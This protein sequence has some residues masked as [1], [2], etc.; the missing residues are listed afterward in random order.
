MI[1]FQQIINGDSGLLAR[2]KI[3]AMLLALTEGEEGI[4]AVW[5]LIR[6]L[7]QADRTLSDEE[8]ADYDELLEFIGD[9]NSH[10][11]KEVSKVYA[12]VDA[13]KGGAGGLIDSP[14]Y[15]PSGFPADEAVTLIALGAGTFIH[16]PDVTGTPITI[17]YDNSITVFYRAANATYWGYNTK[18]LSALMDGTTASALSILSSTY[19]IYQLTKNGSKVAP[20]TVTE[21]VADSERN[22]LLSTLLSQFEGFMADAGNQFYSVTP[23]QK[24]DVCVKDRV[25]YQFTQDHQGAWDDSHAEKISIIDLIY[26]VRGELLETMK[27]FLTEYNVSRHHQRVIYDDF[28]EETYVNDFTLTEAIALVPTE[29]QQ[30]GL[31]ILFIETGTGRWVTY[32]LQNPSWS[33]NELLWEE[34]FHDSVVDNPEYLKV[35]TDKDRRLLEAYRKDGQK[36]LFVPI[37]LLGALIDGVDN[38]E[39]IKVETDRAGH[40]INSIGKDCEAVYGGINV[41]EIKRDLDVAAIGFRYEPETG[42][43]YVKVNNDTT[44]TI[45]YDGATGNL[46]QVKDSRIAANIEIRENGDMYIVQ[47]LK[48]K[49]QII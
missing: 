1:K 27:D 18:V 14:S 29:Y 40:I 46:Y 48:V 10:T 31:K 28:G 34:L 7:Q 8:K 23:Y 5:Q 16:F 9:A 45:R 37:E 44:I 24:G 3:N 33:T 26:Y 42:N 22:I 25:L 20:I 32:Q 47:E 49:R 15:D 41:S 38:P 6:S 4:N 36:V 43:Y 35:V 11:D 39:F 13:M 17:P 19:A 21:A 30:G 2:A 12:Y